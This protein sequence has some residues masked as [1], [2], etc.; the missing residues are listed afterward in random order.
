MR[1]AFAADEIHAACQP[2]GCENH[3]VSQR[4]IS[5][6]TRRP[7][8]LRKLRN[9]EVTL[10]PEAAPWGNWSPRPQ[11]QGA[12]GSAVTI[13]PVSN[14]FCIPVPPTATMPGSVGCLGGG[15]P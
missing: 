11:D 3:P 6:L 14:E 2:A 7:D 8:R 5:A 13:S 15:S 1:R 9:R 10:R 4:E 12:G